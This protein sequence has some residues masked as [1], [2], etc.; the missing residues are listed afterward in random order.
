M[1]L[2]GDLEALLD[3]TPDSTQHPR[4]RPAGNA[5][6]HP[7]AGRAELNDFDGRAGTLQVSGDTP[8]HDWQDILAIALP[9]GFDPAD[10]RIVGNP[11]VTSHTILDED[12]GE[13]IN[14]Q[15]WWKIQFTHAAERG[16]DEDAE[17]LIAELTDFRPPADAPQLV[18]GDFMVYDACDWQL[19]QHDD[20]GTRHTLARLNSIFGKFAQRVHALRAAG[21]ELGTLVIGS[22]GDIYEG[23]KGWYPMQPA[24][25]DLDRRQQT[26]VARRTLV[27]FIKFAYELGFRRIIIIVVPGNHGE[28]RDENGKAFMGWGD[29]DDVAVWEAVYDVIAE[30][31]IAD[32]CEW[33]VPDED[34]TVTADLAGRTIG[35]THGHQCRGRGSS[36][37]A[38]VWD[39]WTQQAMGRTPAGDCQILNVHHFH[40]AYMRE[41]EGRLL[42]GHPAACGTSRWW[43]EMSGQGAAP[44]QTTYVVTPHSDRPITDLEILSP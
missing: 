13:W 4:A 3:P 9:P 16:S 44:G 14:R 10:Y 25:V 36:P 30:T 18:G 19:G 27:K 26:K 6:T 5:H 11:R 2:I 42:I 43:Q 34:L 8:V 29:N 1:S 28:N 38:K 23:C 15:A 31:P 20:G 21:R 35:W 22:G 39:W 24:T 12:T 32:V 7:D 17:R 40:H 41:H 33:I 37:D